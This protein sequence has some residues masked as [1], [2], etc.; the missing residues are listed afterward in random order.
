MWIRNT[1]PHGLV[2]TCW[3]QRVMILKVTFPSLSVD[4]SGHLSH[5]S[6]LYH[7]YIIYA[8]TLLFSIGHSNFRWHWGLHAVCSAPLRAQICGWSDCWPLPG[9]NGHLSINGVT[10]GKHGVKHDKTNFCL[11]DFGWSDVGL[12]DVFPDVSSV[13]AWGVPLFLDKDTWQGKWRNFWPAQDERAPQNRAHKS[14]MSQDAPTVDFNW[15]Y[16]N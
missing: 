13:R 7:F 12:Q 14:S 1:E 9:T 8:S 15:I 6:F 11:T 10:T 3:K 4:L 5:L 2:P 16:R